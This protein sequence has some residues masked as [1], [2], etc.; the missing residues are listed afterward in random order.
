MEQ[1]LYKNENIVEGDKIVI[2]NEIEEVL[3]KNEAITH[4]FKVQQQLAQLKAN[5]EKILKEIEEK[6]WEKSLEQVEKTIKRVEDATGDLGEKLKE[7]IERITE[8][9]TKYVKV[10]KAKRG[11]KQGD[12][13][14]KS[15]V[16]NKILA[17]AAMCEEWKLDDVSHPI[18]AGVRQRFEEI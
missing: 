10:E 16:R 13:N 7:D 3:E 17:D 4:Y 8:E 15:M 9:V 12:K 2:R 1:R 5:R 6:V 11:Y 18:L 14:A